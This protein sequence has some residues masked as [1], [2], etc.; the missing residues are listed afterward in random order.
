MASP[1]LVAAD[2]FGRYAH[3]VNRG[4]AAEV[5]DCFTPDA[6]L[7]LGAGRRFE[8]RAAIVAFY[9][10]Y[11]L[12]GLRTRCRA[13]RHKTSSLHAVD[14]ADCVHA[15]CYYDVD[16]L[17]VS[18]ETD[19]WGLDVL[20]DSIVHNAG[21]YDAEIT[22]ESGVP[23]FRALTIC[24]EWVSARPRIGPTHASDTTDSP[25]GET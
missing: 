6:R 11:V 15:V 5:G 22:T 16:A 8:G 12:D 4:T 24:S 17:V 13:M 23:R 10:G 7:V 21:R 25:Q 20:A 14:A 2:M 9:R 3:A 18:D 1:P 19:I